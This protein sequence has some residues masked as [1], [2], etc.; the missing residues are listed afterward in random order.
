M[1]DAVG[2]VEGAALVSGYP[3]RV[4]GLVARAAFDRGAFDGMPEVG[5]LQVVSAIRAL[6]RAGELW[7]SVADEVPVTDVG[8]SETWPAEIGAGSS[9][10]LSS[11]QAAVMLGVSERRAR[12]LA[13]GGLGR[14]VRGQWRVDRAEVL[15][16]VERRQAA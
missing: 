5:R 3:A 10:D 16:E 14:K 12:Q 6:E 1:V 9:D 11:A 7:L 4:L 8:N 15:A 13:A 2:F